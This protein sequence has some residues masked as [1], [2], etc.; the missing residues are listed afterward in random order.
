MIG[1]PSYRP[2]L[3]RLADPPRN[4]RWPSESVKFRPTA[5]DVPSV[6]W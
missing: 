5:L 4:N 3:M 6:A 1:M 2:P